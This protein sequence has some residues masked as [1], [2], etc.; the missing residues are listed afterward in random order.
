MR[1]S[2]NAVPE[3]HAKQESQARANGL[4]NPAKHVGGGGLGLKR[5]KAST[6][7]LRAA[8]QH[9]AVHPAPK[10]AA[11]HGEEEQEKQQPPP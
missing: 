1:L 6:K 2:C 10:H 5:M 7:I 9:G 3:S 4:R 8:V 11:T